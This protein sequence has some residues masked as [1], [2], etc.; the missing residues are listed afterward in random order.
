MAYV[1]LNPIRAAM[2]RTP[3][4]SDYTSIQD[5]IKN[6]D[7]SCLAQFSEQGKDTLP[8]SLKDYLELVDWGG[9]EINRNKRGYIPVS[10]PPIL[11]R[12]KMNASSVLKYLAKDDQPSSAALGSVSRLSVFLCVPPLWL[13]TVTD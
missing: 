12:L 8:F 13:Y 1:D 2:A 6:P 5:R 7:T 4:Q 11:A 9:H 10:T 3:E